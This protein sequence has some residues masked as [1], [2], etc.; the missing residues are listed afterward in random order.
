M[1]CIWAFLKDDIVFLYLLPGLIHISTLYFPLAVKVTPWGKLF[2][3]F[4]P[5]LKT[6]GIWTVNPITLNQYVFI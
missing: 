6:T 3:F 2:F 1:A 4:L 5:G